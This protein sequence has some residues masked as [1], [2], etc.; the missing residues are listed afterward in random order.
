MYHLKQLSIFRG[1]WQLVAGKVNDLYD[2][3]YNNL[4]FPLSLQNTLTSLLV[5]APSITP[6]KFEPKMMIWARSISVWTMASL[7]NYLCYPSLKLRA[8]KVTENSHGSKMNISFLGPGLFC[9]ALWVL[10]VYR[11]F[12]IIVGTAVTLLP[13]GKRWFVFFLWLKWLGFGVRFLEVLCITF[14]TWTWWF[15]QLFLVADS[16]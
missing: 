3:R 4:F 2:I 11:I 10:G 7:G 15:A 6:R 9:R 5:V 13:H 1:F 14:S 8:K 16:D 12:P